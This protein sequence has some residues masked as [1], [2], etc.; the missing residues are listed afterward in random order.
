MES[1][2]TQDTDTA[3]KSDGFTYR[4]DPN[5]VRT[6]A[7]V[8]VF[9]EVFQISIEEARRILTTAGRKCQT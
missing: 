2:E 6:D 4:L 9:A 7:E 8:A 3:G 5:R 1:M